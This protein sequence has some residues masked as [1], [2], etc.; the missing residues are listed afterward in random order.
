MK[1]FLLDCGIAGDYINDRQGVR[2]R[3]LMEVANGNR[4]GMGVPVLAEVRYGI[5]LSVT[6]ERNMERL[7]RALS[8]LTLWPF[9][10]E[11]AAV[12]A[13]VAADLRRAGR[14]M[15]IFDMM[16]AAI[17]LSLGNC[18][19]V[20]NDSDLLAIPGLAVENW[21]QTQSKPKE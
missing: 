17:A 11:A 12:Y 14:P 8:S 10:E 16:A 5:E 9:T 7:N 18:T 3:A 15:Q 4:L 2:K 19:V 6:R 1:R 13:R 21:A 20:S